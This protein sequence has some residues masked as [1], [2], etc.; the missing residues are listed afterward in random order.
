[1]SAKGLCGRLREE[2]A[3]LHRTAERAGIMRT[4]LAG[5]CDRAAYCRLLRSL[6]ALYDALERALERNRAHAVV[7][8][9]RM[10]ALY[11]AGAVAADLACLEGPGWARLRAASAAGDY[12]SHLES[13]AHA[14]PA[15][16]AAHAYLRYLGDL[17][18][19]RVL[20]GI[21]RRAF[22]LRDGAGTALYDFGSDEDA[23][24]L[25]RDFRGGLDAI[26]A[27]GEEGNAIVAEAKR[28]FALHIRLFEELAAGT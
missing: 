13:L 18:G 8:K 20:R 23:Q 11:R 19:G 14:D 2:T 16:L 28:G 24:R 6:A 7:S 17:S 25:A 9:V 5:Q 15:R 26:P 21:V 1:M 10:P 4:L 22:D 27:H 12:V 3:T